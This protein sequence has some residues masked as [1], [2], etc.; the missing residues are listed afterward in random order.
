VQREKDNIEININDISLKISLELIVLCI[1]LK[2]TY[3]FLYALLGQEY[4]ISLTRQINKLQFC[5]LLQD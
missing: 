3:L 1:I 4:H 5:P 2:E